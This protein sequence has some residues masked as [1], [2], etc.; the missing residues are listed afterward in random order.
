MKNRIEIAQEFA[1]NIKD[2]SIKKIVLYGSVARGDDTED[3]DIDIL[4]VSNHQN[5]IEEK[6]TDEIFNIIVKYRELISAHVIT[7]EHYINT[8][9]YSFLT[10]INKE[11]ILIGWTR[12]KWL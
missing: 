3:S 5:E 10:N 4:I 6:I 1:D 9:N 8:K 11:G 7:E 12:N 2:K